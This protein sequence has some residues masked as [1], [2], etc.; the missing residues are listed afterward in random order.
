MLILEPL[1][2]EGMTAKK[3]QLF[4]ELEFSTKNFKNMKI[5]TYGDLEC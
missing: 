3:T 5:S 4:V 2:K 1:F